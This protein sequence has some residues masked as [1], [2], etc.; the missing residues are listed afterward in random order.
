M[1]NSGL[2]CCPSGIGATFGCRPAVIGNSGL[3]HW[4]EYS[5]TDIIFAELLDAYLS[6][7]LG[8][9]EAFYEGLWDGKVPKR[10]I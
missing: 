6:L 1:G 7:K 3:V 8:S 9:L 5:L 10:L 2:H 4:V